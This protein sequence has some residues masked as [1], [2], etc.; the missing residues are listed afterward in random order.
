M[1]AI[2][3]ARKIIEDS[4]SSSAS[5]TLA[6]LVRAL[7]SKENF[8]LAE[9][10]K[11]DYDSF[12]LGIDVL[13]AWRLDQHYVGKAKLHDLSVQQGDFKKNSTASSRFV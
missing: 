8:D 1:N 4:P 12:H 6:R 5:S 13:K 3:K 11:L 2:K 9:L 10:Y 7:E